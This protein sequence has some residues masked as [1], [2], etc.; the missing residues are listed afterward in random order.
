MRVNLQAEVVWDV[1]EHGDVEAHKDRMALSAIYQAIPKDVLLMLAEKDSA[2]ATWETLQIMHM[3][4]ERVNEA[5][6]QTLKSEFEAIRMKDGESIDDFTMKL[7][8]VVSGIRSLGDVVEEISV[9]KKFLLAILPRFMQIVTSIEQFD[10]LKN[11]SVEEVVGRLKVHEERLRDYEDKEEG[12]YLLLT[13]EEWLA[14]M[15][16]KDAEDSSSSSMSERDS[17]Y[18]EKRCRGHGRGRGG[19]GGRDS[20]TQIDESVNPQKNKSMIKCYSCGKYEHYAAKCGNK[21]HD[22]EANLMFSDDEKP[23]LMLAEKM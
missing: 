9:V 21:E 22:E 2:K 12:K 10:D 1:V 11:M 13:H 17:L 5:K 8:T 14:R 19:R 3:G 4:V 18:K 6:V 16:K 7:T 23:T 20:T 15:K